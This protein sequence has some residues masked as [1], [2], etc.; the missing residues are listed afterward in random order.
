M[1]TQEAGLKAA[2]SS[3]LNIH[4]DRLVYMR[5]SSQTDVKRFASRAT[6]LPTFEAYEEFVEIWDGK[7]P[8]EM[9]GFFQT[10]SAWTFMPT[11]VA[12]VT[13]AIQGI[14]ISIGF[15]LLILLVATHNWIVS[16]VSVLC[17]VIVVMSIVGIM[18]M[19]G[20]ELGTSE[21]ISIVI[22]IGFSVDYTVHLAADYVHSAGRTRHDKM[23]QAYREMGVSVFSGFVTTF[24]CGFFLFFGQLTFFSKFGLLITTTV[25]F[26]ILVALATFGAFMHALGPQEGKG[27]LT[28]CRRREPREPVH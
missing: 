18:H 10:S 14:A 24:G 3:L 16:L 9:K 11:E 19:N 15:A 21:S 2:Q 26:S 27:E 1:T 25:L 17:V 20:Q 4:N 12:F 8:A 22:L 23:R 13:N 28:C 7:A 6:K 5:V